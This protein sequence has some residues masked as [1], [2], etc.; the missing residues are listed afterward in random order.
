MVHVPCLHHLALFLTL[1]LPQCRMESLRLWWPLLG[2]W[3]RC[4]WEPHIGDHRRG[5][6]V[7]FHSLPDGKERPG[8]CACS[9]PH[10]RFP[11][12]NWTHRIAE[13]AATCLVGELNTQVHQVRDLDVH[14]PPQQGC[15][16]PHQCL[17]STPSPHQSCHSGVNPT[18][19]PGGSSRC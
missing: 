4:Q 11:M 10:Q 2:S 14:L 7:T 5:T 19:L 17:L 13:G 1:S 12:E 9:E 16:F 6:Q 15:S 3:R 18:P 8:S